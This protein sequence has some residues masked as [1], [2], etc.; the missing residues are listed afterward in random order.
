MKIGDR[1]RVQ[2]G[3]GPMSG[4][5]GVVVELPVSMDP[6]RPLPETAFATVRFQGEIPPN[7]RCDPEVLEPVE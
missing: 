4:K 6:N 5:T 2:D 1:V 3:Y 7:W